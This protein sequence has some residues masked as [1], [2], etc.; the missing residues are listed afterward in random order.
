MCGKISV[1]AA[2]GLQ[3]CD[4]QALTTDCAE[5]SRT[6]GS[7]THRYGPT[8]FCNLY[9]QP[10]VSAHTKTPLDACRRPLPPHLF[11][12]LHPPTPWPL[13]SNAPTHTL[14]KIIG[15]ICTY[16]PH[17]NSLPCKT[18]RIA[19][20]IVQFFT[21]VTHKNHSQLLSSM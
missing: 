14:S 12:P 16:K 3:T 6:G 17:F 9:I 18:S 8:S 19:I 4:A 21:A 5:G 7:E 15:T 20:L 1:L 11:S 2:R 10:H 13:I